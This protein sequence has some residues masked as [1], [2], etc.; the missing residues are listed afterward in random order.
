[1]RPPHGDGGDMKMCLLSRWEGGWQQTPHSLA[2]TLQ[3]LT[4]G[5]HTQHGLLPSDPDS[6]TPGCCLNN[7]FY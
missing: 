3:S 5:S 6:S 1:M 2:R 4:Q 7:I